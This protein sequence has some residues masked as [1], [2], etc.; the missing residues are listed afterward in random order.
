MNTG[1]FLPKPILRLIGRTPHIIDDE[2]EGLRNAYP[3]DHDDLE[4]DGS[5]RLTRSQP[6]GAMEHSLIGGTLSLL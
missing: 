1:R 4:G 6:P 3:V 2:D 5:S